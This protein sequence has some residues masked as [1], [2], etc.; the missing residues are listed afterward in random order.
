MKCTSFVELKPL[1]DAMVA[2]QDAYYAKRRELNRV[3]RQETKR[4]RCP[5]CRG[6]GVVSG[7]SADVCCPSCGGQG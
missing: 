2:E 6:A 5:R 7:Q 3:S 1:R 4:D